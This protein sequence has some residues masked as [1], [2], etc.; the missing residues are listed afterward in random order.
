MNGDY[1]LAMNR[2]RKVPIVKRPASGSAHQLMPIPRTCVLA[3]LDLHPRRWLRVRCAP[4]L[5][6]DAF[7]IAF[8]DC[9]EQCAAGADYMLRV[10]DARGVGRHHAAKLRLT[11]Q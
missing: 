6:D 3:V 5:R 9:R 10:Q 4:M 8:A 11:A 2:H 1:P 7:E